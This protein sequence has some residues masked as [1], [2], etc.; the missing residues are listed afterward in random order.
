M[1]REFRNIATLRMAR[2]GDP[3]KEI[4]RKTLPKGR[5]SSADFFFPP[6]ES[7]APES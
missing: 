4:R 5:V 7:D 2:E 3:E 6:T 1:Q